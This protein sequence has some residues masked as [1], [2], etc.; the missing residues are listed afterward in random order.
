MQSHY[1]TPVMSLRVQDLSEAIKYKS[2]EDVTKEF[3]N[4]ASFILS[5]AV[6]GKGQKQQEPLWDPKQFAEGQWFSQ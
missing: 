2:H 3:V 1:N 5:A 6:S 4:A